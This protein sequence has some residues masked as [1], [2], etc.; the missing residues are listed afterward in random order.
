MLGSGDAADQEHE[1]IL[2]AAVVRLTSSLSPRC[3]R[4]LPHHR[5]RLQLRIQVALRAAVPFCSPVQARSTCL[6]LWA[7]PT[8]KEKMLHAEEEYLFLLFLS[9]DDL[10]LHCFA[11]SCHLLRYC[12]LTVSWEFRARS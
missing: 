6:L 9:E 7:Q 2:D 3:L 8:W 5:F 1:Q 11:F 4:D 12:F 10:I